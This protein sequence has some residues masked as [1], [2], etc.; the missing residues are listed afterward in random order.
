MPNHPFIDQ[1]MDCESSNKND[2]TSET[3]KGDTEKE[4]FRIFYMSE[5]CMS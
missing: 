2:E 4:K 1:E 5:Q 3:S